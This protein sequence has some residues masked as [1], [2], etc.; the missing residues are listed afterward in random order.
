[1]AV[2]NDRMIR[3]AA[4]AGMISPFDPEC[5]N[6]ASCDLRLGH[7]IR[8]T[9][10]RWSHIGW[11]EEQRNRWCQ[12]S[13]YH[14]AP[15][16]ED[17]PLCFETFWL[18]PGQFILA[19]S[20]EYLR[21][22]VDVTA[23][24]HTKSSTGRIGLDHCL[25]GFIDPGFGLNTEKGSQLTFE[26]VNVSPKPIMLQPGMRLM[27]MVVMQ[28]AEVPEKPYYLTGR[29]NDQQG[30]QPARQAKASNE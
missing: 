16:F 30:A 19:H 17:A 24:L 15:I 12:I 8:V 2:W 18:Y 13:N 26:F 3:R 27:Q 20:L 5:V 11:T 23:F 9:H 4:E 7:E 14:D 6:P 1:M 29:Y 25:A 28:M 22:P 10:F 21:I